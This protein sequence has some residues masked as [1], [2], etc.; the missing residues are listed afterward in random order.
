MEILKKVNVCSQKMDVLKKEI[1]EGMEAVLDERGV[2]APHV[3]PTQLKSM[4]AELRSDPQKS[5][6]APS[7]PEVRQRNITDVLAPLPS[8][9]R[10]P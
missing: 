5:G 7:V 2:N 10:V 8:P 1:C 9:P 4:L 6:P 3:T